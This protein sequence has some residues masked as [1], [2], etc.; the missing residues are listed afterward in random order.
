[1]EKMFEKNSRRIIAVFIVVFSLFFL[2]S[3]CGGSLQPKEKDA[4]I[5]VG[6]KLQME[7]K[8]PKDYYSLQEINATSNLFTN[9]VDG[10]TL[11]IP[12]EFVVDMN[13][14]KIGAVLSDGIW[15]AEIYRQDLSQDVLPDTYIQYSNK[16][17]GNTV[18]HQKEWEE[19][20]IIN[21]YK[22]N[23][24]QWS[25]PAL[26]KVNDDKHYY[27]VCDIIIHDSLV[28]TLAFKSTQPFEQN[29]YYMDIVNSFQLS[30]ISKNG[31]K[32][33]QDNAEKKSQWN[34]STVNIFQKYFSEES[35]LTWGIFEPCAPE[36]MQV[37]HEME[38]YLDY[39]FPF[40]ISYQ[41]FTREGV[42][43]N[44][45][46]ILSNGKNDGKIIELSLQTAD[47][48]EGEG[49]MVYDILNGEFDLY[50]D[51]LAT[52]IAENRMPILM[53]FCNEMNGDWCMYS[54]YHTSRDPEIFKEL[55]KYLYDK[56]EEKG[57]SAYLIW[58]FNPNEKSMPNF[59]WNDQS[60]YYPGDEY[61]DVIGLTGYNTGTYY[62]GEVW[63]SFDQIYGE[64]YIDMVQSYDKPL[65]ITEFASSS[66]GGSKEAW[67]SQ[68]FTQIQKYDKLKV[69]IWWNGRD[70]DINGKVAR[71]YWLNETEISYQAFK[72]GLKEFSR[73]IGDK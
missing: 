40:I 31:I 73:D 10:Y 55:Y 47:Q 33:D 9:Y 52:A 4:H 24:L 49:N 1:M 3:A 63:R 62:P 56:F 53:R 16:F 6:K 11:E 71:P 68:M 67:I 29:N 59:K 26:N 15:Q 41:H 19:S 13:N 30:T 25:R 5:Q 21:G 35:K 58:V 57:A 14:N 43:E 51:E 32:M 23:L 8:D 72:K 54:A 61:A 7:V 39:E 42:P 18:D 2:I 36:F 69:A 66:V 46:T 50:I 38:G 34:K 44:L 64:L 27:A 12:K 70:L 17:I 60:K 20:M 65:M 45:N 37:L 22:V 28:Y 48:D